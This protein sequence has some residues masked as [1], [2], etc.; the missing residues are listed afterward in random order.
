MNAW[1][2]PARAAT[3]VTDAAGKTT[4]T[5]YDKDGLVVSTTDAENNT[6]L[7]TYDEP[8]SWRVKGCRNA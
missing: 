2:K 4:K 5:A 6:T 8:D 3:Q 7:I 1:L